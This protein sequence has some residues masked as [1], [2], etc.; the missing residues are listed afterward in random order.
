MPI[1]T[2]NF[3][4][5]KQQDLINQAPSEQGRTQGRPPFDQDTGHTTLAKIAQ[6]RLKVHPPI[7]IRWE[8]DNLNAPCTQWR[9]TS[10]RRTRCGDD[11]RAPVAGHIVHPGLQRKPQGAIDNDA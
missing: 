1:S 6:Q 11:Q 7:I 5:H 10:H 9:T 2:D 4:C 8:A 3:G